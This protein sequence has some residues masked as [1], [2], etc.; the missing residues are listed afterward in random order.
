MTELITD[1]VGSF[2]L[3][4]LRDISKEMELETSGDIQT[5]VANILKSFQEDGIPYFDESSD[6]LAELLIFCDYYNEDGEYLVDEGGDEEEIKK[7]QCYGFQDDKDP[8]CSGC[9][10]QAAC[11]EHRESLR[12]GCFGLLYDKHAEE[13]KHCLEASNCRIIVEKEK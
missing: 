7:P 12:P 2:N 1:I 3:E 6:L 11:K 8:A 9:P 10:I 5:I 4:E 13:C